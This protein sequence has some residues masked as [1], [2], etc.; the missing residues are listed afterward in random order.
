MS[1]NVKTRGVRIKEIEHV[2]ND[3]LAFGEKTG[4]ANK[5]LNHAHK[6]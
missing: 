4:S 3:I 1:D 5:I 6:Y 2:E